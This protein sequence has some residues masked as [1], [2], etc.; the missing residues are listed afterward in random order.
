MKK[1]CASTLSANGTA[2]SKARTS[3]TDVEPSS[4]ATASA[5][6][7][8][9]PNADTV[10]ASFRRMDVMS[11]PRN[12]RDREMTCGGVMADVGIDV[13]QRPDVRGREHALGRSPG[14]RPPLPHQQQ[15]P[16]Q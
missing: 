16:A 10:R 15:L 8:N 13:V 9:P 3:E 2:R 11:H 12:R 1:I 4:G 6:I 7:S 14:E 5:A